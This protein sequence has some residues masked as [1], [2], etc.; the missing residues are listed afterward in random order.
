VGVLVD[1]DAHWMINKKNT[2]EI[3]FNVQAAVG[4][5]NLD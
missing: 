5:S 3:S 4:L 2:S 1:N